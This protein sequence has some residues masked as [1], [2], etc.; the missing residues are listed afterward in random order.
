MG[1][2]IHLGDRNGV[3]TPM[4]WTAD[5]NAG[6][7]KADP[8]QLFLPVVADAIYGYQSIN[9]EAQ[10]PVAHSL[11]NWMRRMIAIRKQHKVFGRGTLEFLNPANEKILAYLRS[12]ENETVLMVHNLAESAQPLE[13]GSRPIQRDR[14]YRTLRRVALSR[15]RRASL[16][17]DHGALW[18]LLAESSRCATMGQCVQHRVERHL[19]AGRRGRRVNQ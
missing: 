5:R 10:K 7:S 9:V 6:F 3:R 16:C 4:H 8:A 13:L 19:T 12:Y 18:F 11:L 17:P 14:A 15:N 1:D 2:N